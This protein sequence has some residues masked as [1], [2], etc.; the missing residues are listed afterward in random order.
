MDPFAPRNGLYRTHITGLTNGLKIQVKKKK[1]NRFMIKIR[2][3]SNLWRGSMKTKNLKITL[4]G[5]EIKKLLRDKLK[6][7]VNYKTKLYQC[8]I[9]K[10][11]K[12]IVCTKKKRN[13]CT[14]KRKRTKK[15]K[16]GRKHLRNQSTKPK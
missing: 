2:K 14:K 5:K 13:K 15:K 8:K 4:K 10:K 16:K 11:C 3:S 1:G 7:T 12:T 6:R 9:L